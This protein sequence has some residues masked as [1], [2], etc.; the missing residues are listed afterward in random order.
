MGLALAALMLMTVGSVGP[1]TSPVAR[2]PAQLAARDQLPLTFEPNAGQVDPA[3]RFLAHATGGTLFFTPN[4]VVLALE[5]RACR[6]T[7]A[8]ESGPGPRTAAPALPQTLRLQFVDTAPATLVG[9]HD[10]PGR[11]NYLRGTDPRG[12]ATDLPTYTG[13]TYSGLYPGVDLQFT[14]ADGQLK[15]TY[16]VAAGADPATIRWRYAGARGVRVDAAGN[17]HIAWAGEPLIEQAPLAWQVRDGQRVAVAAHYSVA[18]DG[19]IGFVLGAYDRAQPLTLDP[20]LTYSTYLGG[21]DADEATGIAVDSAGNVYLTGYTYS[22]NF[23]LSN[24]YQG[25]MGGAFDVFVTKL[26]ADGSSLIYSTYLGGSGTESGAAIAVDGAGNATIT[27][28]TYSTNFPIQNALQ[29]TNAGAP[30][31]FLTKLNPAGSG[32]VFSTYLGGSSGDY[33]TGVALSPTGD[34]YLS[35][36]TQ[37]TNFPVANPFRPANAG[38]TD[39]FVTRFNAA[40]SGLVYST[41]LGGSGDDQALGVAVDNVGNVYI[42][43]YTQSANFPL[44]NAYQPTYGGGTYDAFVSVLNTPGAA[45]IY[46]TYLGGSS[47]DRAAAIRVDGSGNAYVTGY[48]QSA[49]FPTQAA[50]QP[51]NAGATDAFL[52]KFNAIGSGLIYSTYLGGNYDDCTVGIAADGAGDLYTAGYTA[53][54]N[55]PVVNAIQPTNGGS[56]DA[57]AAKLGGR[58]STIQYSTYLGGSEYELLSGF[59]LDAAGNVTLAGETASPNFPTRNPFQAANAGEDD[60]FVSKLSADGALIYSTYLGGGAE[61]ENWGI[62]VDGA[63]SAYISGSTHSPDFPTRN[64]VQPQYAGEGDAFVTKLSSTGAALVYSTY[65]GGAGADMGRGIAVD[66]GGTVYLGGTTASADFPLV[67]PLQAKYGGKGDAFAAALDA[68]GADLRYTTFIGG[69]GEDE[70]RGLALDQGGNVY[71]TGYT[72]SPDFPQARAYQPANTGGHEVFVV[73]LSPRSFTPPRRSDTR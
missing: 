62:A 17:L 66:Q 48:T 46:S 58:G 57:F 10:A 6:P 8:A 15:G 31:G 32:L 40:G 16:A 43:G 53:S 56:W 12:W 39:A 13:I 67:A 11:V 64:A 45:L 63:G 22:T 73:A 49:N 19:S 4:E 26:S 34:V 24:A 37:S 61:D 47:L 50:F 1:G 20:T 72:T 59:A 52:T 35:G 5:D 3:V 2:S 18:A 28:Y 55:F 9:G 65:L 25:S 33:G 14:G 36:Y 30:D 71:L 68:N 42:S 27:G 54:T 23:P 7:G 38:A 21:S 60:A 41:Y 69:S 29:A 70:S 44:N 51:G